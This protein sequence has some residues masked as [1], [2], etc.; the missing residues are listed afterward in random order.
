MAKP[1]KFPRDIQKFFMYKKILIG[2]V[3][4]SRES[5]LSVE[6]DPRLAR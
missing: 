6:F 2:S 5:D 4:D 1:R 3:F